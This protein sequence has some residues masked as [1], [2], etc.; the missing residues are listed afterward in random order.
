[1]SLREFRRH[2]GRLLVVGFDGY[3]VG[4]DLRALA[5]EFDLGGAVLFERNLDQPRQVA[6]LSR[7]LQELGAEVPPWVAI[8]QEGGRVARLPPPFTRWPPARV[9]GSCGD[10][11][12]V[13]RFARALAAELRAA[14]VTLDF[15]PVLD[16]QTNPANTVIGDRAFSDRPDVVARLGRIVI[17]TLQ[18]AGVAACGKH[19][20]GHGDTTA[21]S[22]VELPIV[23]HPLERL[24]RVEFV[25]FAEAVRAGVAALMTAHVLVPALDEE[26]PATVSPSVLGR[27]RRDLGFDGLVLA[28][29]LEMAALAG[30]YRPEEAAVRAIAAGCDL[31]LLCR[32][33]HDRH[34]AV[35]EALIHAVGD[36]TLPLARVEEAL[37]RDRRAKERLLA[38]E[39]GRPPAPALAEVLERREH[40][41]LAEQIARA[42]S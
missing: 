16:V 14:G 2:A 4:A 41:A 29:D 25:P 32:P 21:D 18:A 6:D 20:P 24:Q 40:L 5:R 30:R 27:L 7:E 3:E 12:L 28:D 10:D 11:G 35:V 23:E 1:M 19:F 9:L 31:V 42:A 13:R 8:D 33:D 15:A 37:R 26:R 34:A 36:G 17:E 38:P 39:P 22:H